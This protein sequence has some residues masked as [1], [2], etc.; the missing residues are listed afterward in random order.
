[1]EKA[2][3][4]KPVQAGFKENL[5]SNFNKFLPRS[6]ENPKIQKLILQPM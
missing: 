3:L 1:M 4:F 6:P 2:F 5:I